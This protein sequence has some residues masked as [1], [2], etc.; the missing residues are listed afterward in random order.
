M[1]CIIYICMYLHTSSW[2]VCMYVSIYWFFSFFNIFNK[3]KNHLYVLHQF[4]MVEEFVCLCDPR[5]YAFEGIWSPGTDRSYRWQA[6]QRAIHNTEE[7]TAWNSRVLRKHPLMLRN[8][9][10]MYSSLD[11]TMKLSL[12]VIYHI[13]L[14]GVMWS[15]ST[16]SSCCECLSLVDVKPRFTLYILVTCTHSRA[17]TWWLKKIVFMWTSGIV[18]WLEHKALTLSFELHQSLFSK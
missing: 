10:I 13:I 11:Q 8:D 2:Y 16:W 12:H 9:G 4:I 14:R 7:K 18:K 3:I 5:S 1:P 6:R 15:V 17:K